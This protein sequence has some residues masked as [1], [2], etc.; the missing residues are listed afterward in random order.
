[1]NIQEIPVEQLMD[2]V[3]FVFQDVFL[4]NDTILE[5]IR[6]GKPDASEAEVMAAA[7]IA[8]CDE[9][10]TAL[11]QGYHTPIGENGIRLSGG[12]RQRLSIARAVLK[13]APIIVLDE[14][15]AYVDP[16]NEALV[17]EAL[18]G[19]LTRGNKTLVVIAHRLSTITE[20][21]QILVIAQGQV[22]AQG[23]HTELLETCSLYREQWQAHTAAQTWQ[24]GRG[25]ETSSPL[26]LLS[27]NQLQQS[28]IGS[29]RGAGVPPLRGG[30]APTPPVHNQFVNAVGIE[31]VAFVAQSRA[32]APYPAQNFLA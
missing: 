7:R 10:I 29:E 21:D 25:A 14:A 32:I 4:F 17:Q 28:L 1:M 12:Q 26:P 15:T 24:L 5:N 3:S 19:L 20:A 11:P 6:I 22:M 31:A 27:H 13:D 16:E 8:R 9:F 2:T 23:S 18:A 30:V